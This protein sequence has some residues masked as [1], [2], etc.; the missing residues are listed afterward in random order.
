MKNHSEKTKS[1]D[2]SAFA[3]LK[4]KKKKKSEIDQKMKEGE[5]KAAALTA[6]ALRTLASKTEVVLDT[7]VV[8]ARVAGVS[9]PARA[10]TQFLE[11]KQRKLDAKLDRSANPTAKLHVLDV[12][13]LDSKTLNM[14]ADLV[15]GKC[16][17]VFDE[18]QNVLVESNDV[19][20]LAGVEVIVEMMGYATASGALKAMDTAVPEA[21]AKEAKTPPPVDKL[22]GVIMK[23]SPK[24]AKMFKGLIQVVVPSFSKISELDHSQCK[25]ACKAIDIKLDLIGWDHKAGSAMHKAR[26]VG[27]AMRSLIWMQQDY[28]C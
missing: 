25:L 10:L 27:S 6:E 11:L 7:S 14:M 2:K 26:R 12:L 19:S 16:L 18:K 5:K 24:D 1:G 8:Q 23:S 9:M 15:E 28:C 3:G 4:G 20:T 22:M 17:V 21:P 13:S